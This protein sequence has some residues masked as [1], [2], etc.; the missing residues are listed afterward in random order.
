MPEGLCRRFEQVAT[1]SRKIV[2]D[3]TCDMALTPPPLKRR[4]AGK[5]AN[6][7]TETAVK[8]SVVKKIKS[9]E[10]ICACF[11]HQENKTKIR[12]DTRI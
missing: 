8:P 10:E 4:K 3:G 5:M 9:G 11:S 6:K 12:E 1:A 2:Q 7:S